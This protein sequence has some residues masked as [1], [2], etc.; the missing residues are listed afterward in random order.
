MRNKSAEL[1]N[2]N[3]E[4]KMPDKNPIN[5]PVS[6][7]SLDTYFLPIDLPLPGRGIL[8]YSNVQL[9]ALTEYNNKALLVAYGSPGQ[10]AIMDL[11]SNI[12]S[13]KILSQDS[14]YFWNNIYVL[15]ISRDRAERSS[16]L[17]LQKG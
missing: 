5:I 1:Q 3:I 9:S 6:I 7:D 14:L 2:A 8:N 4:I 15:L 13:E 12:F 11:D 10:K 16:A 17:N